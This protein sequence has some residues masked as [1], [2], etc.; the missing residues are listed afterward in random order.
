[1]A[2]GVPIGIACAHR[3]RLNNALAPVLDLMQT[4]PTMVYLLSLIHI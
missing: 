4:L 3:P 1:M 2:L